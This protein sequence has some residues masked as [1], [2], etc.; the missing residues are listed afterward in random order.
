[1]PRAVRLPH[2]ISATRKVNGDGYD[3]DHAAGKSRNSE[4]RARVFN[5]DGHQEQRR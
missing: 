1:M 2:A 3:V 4:K 5:R